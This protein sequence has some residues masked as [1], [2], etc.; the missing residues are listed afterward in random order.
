M[1]CKNF[2]IE[3]I[4]KML[5]YIDYLKK[6]ELY[7]PVKWHVANFLLFKTDCGHKFE[8]PDPI[9]FLL[10]CTNLIKPIPNVIHRAFPFVTILR[11]HT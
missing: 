10:D 6:E 5:S 3:Y 1:N 9:L 8:N 4:I 7:I 2:F 11:E